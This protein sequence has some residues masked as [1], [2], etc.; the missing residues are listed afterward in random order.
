[1]TDE[2]EV[3]HLKSVMKRNLII[4]WIC[5]SFLVIAPIALWLDKEGGNILPTGY[6]HLIIGGII[7]IG[8]I[9]K[10]FKTVNE[11]KS[12]LKF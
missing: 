7:I 11:I 3:K 6:A 8:T 12:Q 2:G 10:C 9:V 5:I 4:G 1:M